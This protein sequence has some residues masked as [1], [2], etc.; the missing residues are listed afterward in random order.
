MTPTEYRSLAGAPPNKYRAKAVVVHGIR[1][2]STGEANRWLTLRMLATRGAISNLRRQVKFPLVIR[3]EHG[4]FKRTYVA[5]FVYGENGVE[6]VEDWKGFA[7]G[8]YKI[9]RDLMRVLHGI[10]IRETGKGKAR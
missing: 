9:K 4:E 5:D 6:I 7:T 1:F 8:D 2:H 10:T 3:T